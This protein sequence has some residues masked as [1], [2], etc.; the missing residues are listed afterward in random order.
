MSFGRFALGGKSSNGLRAVTLKNC[1]L[2]NVEP[3]IYDRGGGFFEAISFPAE[4]I[5]LPFHSSALRVF[6]FVRR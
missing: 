3:I 5:V 2:E 4:K 1:R 6:V